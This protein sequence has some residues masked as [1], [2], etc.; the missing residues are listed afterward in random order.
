V[1]C[2]S[3]T[4]DAGEFTTVA[5]ASQRPASASCKC[6]ATASA[7]CPCW[8]TA[9]CACGA[10]YS[11]RARGGRRRRVARRRL[12]V[13]TAGNDT[14]F[15]IVLSLV[16]NPTTAFAKMARGSIHD[17]DCDSGR[18][19]TPLRTERT[20]GAAFI[21]LAPVEFNSNSTRGGG[22]CGLLLPGHF[23]GLVADWDEESPS[24]LAVSGNARS[25]IG[26][27]RSLAARIVPA[28]GGQGVESCGQSTAPGS[29]VGDS[30]GGWSGGAGGGECGIVFATS[31]AMGL[32]VCGART[33]ARNAAATRRF[34]LSAGLLDPKNPP[35]GCTGVSKQHVDIPGDVPSC[36][37][38]ST[39]GRRLV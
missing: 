33:V 2:A 7:S 24:C 26:F 35:A 13:V 8:R 23:R 22:V 30:G 25:E 9:R 38:A 37:S 14:D 15:V 31:M 34:T 20:A 3:A 39:G 19:T 16:A 29:A 11:R 21:C 12:R 10:G 32:P 36:I 27:V 17:V 4:A 5:L 1:A 28:A 18:V 6:C